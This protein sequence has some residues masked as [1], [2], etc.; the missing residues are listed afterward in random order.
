MSAAGRTSASAPAQGIGCSMLIGAPVPGATEVGDCCLV[1]E[2]R[3]TQETPCRRRS[4]PLRERQTGSRCLTVTLGR[5]LRDSQTQAPC[6]YLSQVPYEGQ[7]LMAGLPYGKVVTLDTQTGP[8]PRVPAPRFFKCPTFRATAPPATASPRSVCR[9]DTYSQGPVFTCKSVLSA[10]EMSGDHSTALRAC[11]GLCL[12]LAVSRPEHYDVML[13]TRKAFQPLSM[14]RR[15][16][17]GRGRLSGD[18]C[19]P[20]CYRRHSG[21][22]A[23]RELNVPETMEVFAEKRSFVRD[24]GCRC[25]G[26]ENG[27]LKENS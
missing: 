16:E 24:L 6:P 2:L 13:R 8:R 4:G 1:R 11:P 10:P 20:F 7:W 17:N 18:T 5:R 21:G 15:A 23:R 22:E 27:S 19:I 14:S 9:K 26:M 25:L 3:K 12:I